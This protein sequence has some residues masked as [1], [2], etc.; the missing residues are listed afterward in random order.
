MTSLHEPHALG[1]TVD[2]AFTCGP[3]SG[4]NAMMGGG[5]GIEYGTGN[6]MDSPEVGMARVTVYYTS[7][8]PRIIA[9]CSFEWKTGLAMIPLSPIPT[10]E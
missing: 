6:A 5:G 3:N 1:D 10:Q 4:W 8:I 2:G 9:A 7:D